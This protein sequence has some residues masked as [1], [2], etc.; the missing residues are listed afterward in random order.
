VS[1]YEGV[2][3][4]RITAARRRYFDHGDI[5]VEG[6]P[7]SVLRSW[8]RCWEA[9]HRADY[10]VAFE[11]IGRSRV[12]EIDERNRAL[13]E[14]AREEVD[15][16]CRV[17]SRAQMIV[18][19]TDA[20][21]IVV[22][23]G[24]NVDAVSPRLRLAARKGVD[25]S[26]ATIGTNAVGTALLE[27]GAVEIV[28]REHYFEANAVHTC[29]AAPLFAPDGSLVGALDVSGDYRPDRANLVDLVS[30]SARAIENRLLQRMPGVCLLT[31]SQRQDLLDTP[32]EA[33]A[34]FDCSGAMVGA[35]TSARS[36]L[37]L[38][39]APRPGRFE[40]LFEGRFA[41]ALRTLAQRERPS[42]L[43]CTSGVRVLAR[44]HG[45]GTGVR[46][47]TTAPA[48][49]PDAA[50]AAAKRETTLGF[51]EIVSRDRTT[52]DAVGRARCAYDR[53]V[54]MLLVGETGTGKELVARALHYL[55]ARADGPFVAVNCASL[56]E[57]LVEAEL[58][59]YVEGAFTGARRGGAPGRLE[60]A[61]G[62]TLFLDE[63]GDMPLPSQAKLL[64]VLQERC[65]TRLGDTRERVIDF[66][67]VCA[68]HQQLLRLIAEKAFRED[69]YYRINGLCV[70][71]PP[72][73]QRSNILDLVHHLLRQQGSHVLSPEAERLLLSHAWPGNLRQLSHVVRCA[74]ALAGDARVIEP[75][76]FPEDF[77]AA[78]GGS[79]AQLAS[80]D[81]LPTAPVTLDQAESLLIESTLRAC[82]GNVSAAARTLGVSRSTLYNKL[83]R[84]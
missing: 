15:E 4:D 74:M 81:A 16:L 55:G 48:R 60:L 3:A 77:L 23:A 13:V 64:R 28:A 21:G 25:M 75:E 51:L 68:T 35:N 8:R 41:E 6:V 47:R 18:L 54:P 10:P 46:V 9:G 63:I 22:E 11:M 27:N 62:G 73:R 20:A 33:I 7:T 2:R 72:L 1:G 82:R 14:A 65:V 70:T 38:L 66:A 44:M 29:V 53:S 49:M 58:F 52:A 24:G 43:Q 32:W 78:A 30:A 84:S 79:A 50:G 36:L 67:L 37:G 39:A 69:L 42:S 45:E 59:G 19:L 56:P 57:S 76:H 80:G 12:R 31:F 71:L 61:H 83:K 26:E 5:A 17:V 40:D 34:A